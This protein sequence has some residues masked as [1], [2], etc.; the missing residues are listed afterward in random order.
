MTTQTKSSR[1]ERWENMK[2]EYHLNKKLSKKASL[3]LVDDV[4]TTG[5]TIHSCIEALKNHLVTYILLQLQLQ[6]VD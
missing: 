2:N 1:F 5:A 4:I 3:L 6:T